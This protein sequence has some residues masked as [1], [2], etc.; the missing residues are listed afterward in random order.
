MNN[1]AAWKMLKRKLIG[2]WLPTAGVILLILLT[3]P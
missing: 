1:K 2:V 3:T